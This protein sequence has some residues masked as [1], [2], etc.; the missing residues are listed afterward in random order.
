M[1][2]LVKEWI[3]TAQAGVQSPCSTSIHDKRFCTVSLIARIASIEQASTTSHAPTAGQTHH[4][5][6]DF[7][8]TATRADGLGHSRK[9]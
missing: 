5:A 7:T 3:A 8:A 1:Q 2:S 4:S 9:K 6:M